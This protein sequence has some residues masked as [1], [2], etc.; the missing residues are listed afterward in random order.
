MIGVLEEEDATTFLSLFEQV[1][2]LEL[3]RDKG[4]ITVF[5]PTNDAFGKLDRATIETLT[6]DAGLLESVLKNHIV[7]DGKIFSNVIVDDLTAETL[8]N[9][10]LRFNT[11]NGIVSVNGAEL[12]LDRVDERAS[13]GVIHFLKDVIYPLPQGSIYQTLSNDNRFITLVRAIDIAEL[14]E[15][16]D[17]EDTGPFTVFAPTDA[18]FDLIPEEALNELLQDKDALRK[19]LLNHVVDGTKLSQALTFVK[20]DSL[21]EKPVNVRVKKG[22]VFV[23]DATLTD[24]DIVATNGAI[25]VIDRVLL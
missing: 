9:T 4:P 14:N 17:S 16:L 7:P 13:N 10:T 15:E 1:D 22:S 5:A 24:G 11:D 12:D 2:Q 23:N 6:D 18:A 19:L 20:L 25:Q 21:G 8:Q 3:L